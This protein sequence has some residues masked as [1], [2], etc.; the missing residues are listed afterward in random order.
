M[1]G[2]LLHRIG[3]VQVDILV[4]EL[5]FLIICELTV[6]CPKS[7]LLVEIKAIIVVG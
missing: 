1:I 7:P 2:G 6:V 4:D 5:S 3:R